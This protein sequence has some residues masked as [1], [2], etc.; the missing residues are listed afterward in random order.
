MEKS[1]VQSFEDSRKATENYM[2]YIMRFGEEQREEING[3][4]YSLTSIIEEV[5]KSGTVTV[6]AANESMQSHN[7]T[8]KILAAI[9]KAQG[10]LVQLVKELRLNGGDGAGG[11]TGGILGSM[12]NGAITAATTAITVTGGTA[13]PLAGPIA[14]IGAAIGGIVEIFEE[15]NQKYKKEYEEASPNSLTNKALDA[16]IAAE[17][18]ANQTYYS[19]NPAPNPLMNGPGM[20]QSGVKFKDFPFAQTPGDAFSVV[21]AI[22]EANDYLEATGQIAPRSRE[23]GERFSTNYNDT[24][25]IPTQ[26]YSEA[27]I[28]A[29]QPQ[30]VQIITQQAGAAACAAPE[31]TIN[32]NIQNDFKGNWQER[33]TLDDIGEYLARQVRDRLNSGAP[34]HSYH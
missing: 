9:T 32:F 10:T 2:A 28:A 24:E 29:M 34:L 8:F 6:M 25:G 11:K 7:S 14:A 12:V 4:T 5:R 20:V 22:N 15:A 27:E 30:S 13:L 1:L 17:K 3:A 18:V 19:L 26:Y 21:A 33:R 31:Q 16:G 23:L